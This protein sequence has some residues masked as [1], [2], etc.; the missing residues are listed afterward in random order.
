LE[1]GLLFRRL[2]AAPVAVA[3]L[4]LSAVATPALAD[5]S[6][7]ILPAAGAQ[8]DTFTVA[9]TGIQPGMALDINFTSPEGTVFTTA[10]LNQVV[11]VDGDGNFSFPFVPTTEFVGASFGTWTAQVCVS[12][13]DTCVQ[14]GFDINA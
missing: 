12:G 3:L 7:G 13:T 14:G 11:V 1:A 8:A 5:P 4:L 9:G 10:A 2:V 6:V